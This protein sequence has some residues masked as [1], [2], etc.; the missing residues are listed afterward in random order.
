MLKKIMNMIFGIKITVR[1]EIPDSTM[2]SIKS[3]STLKNVV[4]SKISQDLA[5]ELRKHIVIT[6]YKNINK[7]STIFTASIK[8]RK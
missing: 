1:M 3:G 2:A 6:K 8:I 7:K 4:E 5:A